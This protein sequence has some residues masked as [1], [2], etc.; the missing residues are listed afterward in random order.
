LRLHPNDLYALGAHRGGIDERWLAS[1][2]RADNGPETPPDEGLSYVEFDGELEPL[3]SFVGEDWQVLCK[4]FDNSI[5]I[6]HHVHPNDAQVTAQ[7]LKGKPEAYYFPPQYNANPGPFPYTF[8]GLEPHTS[9]TDIR[10][11]LERWSEGDNGILYHSRAYK[12]KP[13]TGWQVDANVLH[14]P[15]TMVT[16]EPQ[17]ASDTGAMFESICAGEP[18]PWEA[19]VKYIPEAHR[20]DL[21]YILSWIDFEKNTDPFFSQVYFRKPMRC[22]D[23]DQHIEKWIVYGSPH[24]CAKELTVGPGASVRITDETAYGAL[25]VQGHGE[26]NGLAAEVPA[27]IR[28]GQ[29]TADEFFVTA[30][31]ARAGVSITNRSHIE[32]LVILK[33]FGPGHQAAAEFIEK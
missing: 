13:G 8:F 24:F 26:M 27:M 2:V 3:R 17:A 25:V 31:A 16:Y 4:L 23:S 11:C 20:H 10:R 21:D 22:A 1:T 7:G 12:L 15:G 33:H 9:R 14:A 18:L 29:M 5:P 19:L 30:E 32:P 28:F 6:P